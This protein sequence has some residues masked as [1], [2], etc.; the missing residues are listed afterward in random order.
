[1]RKNEDHYEAGERS[2][3][4]YVSIKKDSRE[5]RFESI[6]EASCLRRVGHEITN[7]WKERSSMSTHLVSVISRAAYASQQHRWVQHLQ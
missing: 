4:I 3:Q 6:D 7:K 5:I 1:M 2:R